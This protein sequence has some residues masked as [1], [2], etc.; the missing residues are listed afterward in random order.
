MKRRSA[1]KREMLKL[2]PRGFSALTVLFSSDFQC[3]G[4]DWLSLKSRSCGENLRGFHTWG[5]WN[6][7]LQMSGVAG[8]IQS[9]ADDHGHS[10]DQASVRTAQAESWKV[11]GI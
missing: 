9:I 11:V 3:S 7:T 2:T 8:S 6:H 5:R 10:R 4:P 1:G